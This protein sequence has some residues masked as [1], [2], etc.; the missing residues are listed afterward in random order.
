[1]NTLDARRTSRNT[2]TGAWI[3]VQPRIVNRLS[4]SKD[5]WRDRIQRIYRFGLVDLPKCCDSCGAKFMIEHALACKKGGLVLGGHNEVKAETDCIAIQVLGSNRVRNK[6][7]IITCCDTPNTQMPISACT[8]P[9]P[10]EQNRTPPPPHTHPPLH[11]PPRIT[12]T[13]LTA[14]T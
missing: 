5:E 11:L 10:H 3:S 13:S 2:E 14:A 9:P 4:L 8:H 7:K 12:D 1:M 6:L